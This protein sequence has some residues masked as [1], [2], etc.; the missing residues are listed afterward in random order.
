[1][2]CNCTSLVYLPELPAMNLARGCYLE[3]FKDC[4][5][6][7]TPQ[8]I[9]PATTLTRECYSGMFE[10]CSELL[11]A[12]ELPALR[13]VDSCYDEM[14]YGCHSLKYVK[15]L[16]YYAGGMPDNA[17]DYCNNWLED[18]G[19]DYYDKWNKTYYDE[20][21]KCIFVKHPNAEAGNYYGYWWNYRNGSGIP[22][23]WVI[24]D[25]DISS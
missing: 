21:E 18:A 12:P 7:E 22:E 2:F 13:L 19:T 3:M 15:C 10:N 6:I 20:D 9:L 24:E 14:F 11:V 1:M 5:N 16:A 4:Y 25:A 8:Q 17:S 23:M